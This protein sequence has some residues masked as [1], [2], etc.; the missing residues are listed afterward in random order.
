MRLEVVHI[1]GPS[2]AAFSGISATATAGRGLPA[3]QQPKSWGYPI[4][5]WMLDGLEGKSHHS[6]AE[7]AGSPILS[8]LNRRLPVCNLPLPLCVLVVVL[9][10]HLVV[11][12]LVS[13][14]YF[15]AENSQPL[16]QF[17]VQVSATHLP[18]LA[19]GVGLAKQ[20]DRLILVEFG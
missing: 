4:P 19:F 12:F 3:F 7:K 11:F 20:R 10:V 9:L 5:R 18:S 8:K 17:P 16:S 1:L 6:I 13:Y 15:Y 14:S 2:L